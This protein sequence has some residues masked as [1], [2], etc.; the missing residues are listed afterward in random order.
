[1]LKIMKTIRY[2][3]LKFKDNPLI[4]SQHIFLLAILWLT[5]TL[6]MSQ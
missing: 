4:Q 6:T 3:R 1:M 2:I 5:N